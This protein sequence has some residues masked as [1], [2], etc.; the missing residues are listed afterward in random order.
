MYRCFTSLVTLTPSY[1]ISIFRLSKLDS[2]F[3]FFLSVF[4]LIHRK[5]SGFSMLILQL[6][7]FLK[8]LIS[9]MG[10]LAEGV[11]SCL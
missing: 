7:P 6:S 3:D 5:G 1:F 11:G 4:L 8:V 10:F 2:S 9:S